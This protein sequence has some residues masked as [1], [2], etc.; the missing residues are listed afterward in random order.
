MS[1]TNGPP[2][3]TVFANG[4][5]VVTDQELNGFVQG[6]ALLANL[7]AFVGLSGMMVWMVGTATA[8]D[9][10]EGGFYW[11]A[12]STATDDGGLTNIQPNGILTGRWLRISG[13]TTTSLSV[14]TN[15]TALRALT[16]IPSSAVYVEGYATLADGGEGIFE[17]N[18]T[19]LTTADNGW[20]VIVDA[21]GH[22]WY[23]ARST[24]NIIDANIVGASH[25]YAVTDLEKFI[26]RNNAGAVMIDTLPGGA[27][28]LPAGA[29]LTISNTDTAMLAIQTPTGTF[30]NYYL[31][32]LLYVGPGQ[33]VKIW[34]NGVDSYVVEGATRARCNQAL[35]LYV[36]TTGSDTT[37]S[38]LTAAAPFLTIAHATSVL[39]NSF[40]HNGFAP[41]IHVADGSYAAGAEGFVLVN[42]PPTG[43]PEF[44]LTG[45]TTTPTNVV[46]TVTGAPCIG[47]GG[48]PQ[49]FVQGFQIIAHGTLGLVAG[50]EGLVTWSGGEINFGYCDFNV[51]DVA[52]ITATSGGSVNSLDQP[53]SISAI[54]AGAAHIACSQVGV[55]S[56]A[57]SVVTIPTALAF[58]TFTVVAAC[59][60]HYAKGMSFT[61][62]G[63][64]GTTGYR[65][66]ASENGVIETG[67]GASATF[68]PGNLAGGTASGGQYT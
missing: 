10:G 51:C 66:G 9:G 38:G 22:R 40:D 15:I 4:S 41:T 5:G 21:V 26:F 2:Q 19:D 23:R 50:G 16:T 30:I 36:A 68:F 8:G 33:T 12:S 57:N 52:H 67:S 61:G 43:T 60:V 56:T 46:L 44:H 31:N 34:S 27:S 48:G 58:G 7:R 63:V 54:G 49:V 13:S 47:V 28:I 39:Y 64:A 62:A 6:G 37:N 25:T 24:S 17:Y 20:T 55:V 11:N 3:L 53:Y 59:A 45:N 42:G 65:F 18:S 1:G 14:I 32:G 29:I 35:S